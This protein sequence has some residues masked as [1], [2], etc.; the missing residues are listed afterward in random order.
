MVSEPDVS[1]PVEDSA[2]GRTSSVLKPF[3]AKETS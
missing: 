3:L 1:A 2:A